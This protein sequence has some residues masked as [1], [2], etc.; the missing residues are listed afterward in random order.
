MSLAG[1]ASIT[2]LAV[3]LGW[4]GGWRYSMHRSLAEWQQ[5]CGHVWCRPVEVA[6]DPFNRWPAIYVE[7]CV[8]CAAQRPTDKLGHPVRGREK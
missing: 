4:W 3:V 8:R 6:P 2:V 7:F 1:F 5:R